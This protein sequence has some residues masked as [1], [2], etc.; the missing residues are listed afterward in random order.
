MIKTLIVLLSFI[1]SACLTSQALL[2]NVSKNKVAEYSDWLV[3]VESNPQQCWAVS[4]PLESKATRNGKL[5][6]VKR[7][8]ILLFVN[9]FGTK[10]IGPQIAFTPGFEPKSVKFEINNGR[11]F[12]LFTET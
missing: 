3:F 5:V 11:K 12:I 10:G 2:A 1:C 4:A 7:K 6:A 9:F 8:D